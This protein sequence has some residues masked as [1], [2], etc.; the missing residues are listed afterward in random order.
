[1]LNLDSEN[2]LTSTPIFARW[3][4]SLT[5]LSRWLTPAGLDLAERLLYYDPT[6][7]V[8]AQQAL[9]SG[10]FKEEQPPPMLPVGWV[11]IRTLFYGDADD[12]SQIIDPRGWM[13]RVRIQERTS[14]KASETWSFSWTSA[15]VMRRPVILF[16]LPSS[17]AD[18]IHSL[19][20]FFAQYNAYMMT[21]TNCSQRSD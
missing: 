9:E 3:H 17:V 21:F 20:L 19:H 11:L 2:F 1:M 13:A 6:Q 12:L 7:R 14:K 18:P 5:C 15:S 10:Y 8:T 4:C 16:H